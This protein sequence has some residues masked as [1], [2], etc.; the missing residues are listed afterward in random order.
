MALT[1][2]EEAAIRELLDQQA[3]LLSL[4]SNEA[5]I[6]SKLGATIAFL[7]D[8]AAASSVNAGDLLLLRQGTTD[9]SVTPEILLAPFFGDVGLGA[10]V[11][12][13]PAADRLPYFTGTGT[14]ALATL[15]ASG[16]ALIASGNYAAMRALLDLEPGV[17]VQAYDGDLAAI[18]AL[19]T[20]SFGRSLLTLAD[21][22]DF[23]FESGSNANGY[24]RRE[25]D[26]FIK[27]WGFADA[28]EPW[29]TAQ[30][31]PIPFT[32]F[33]SIGMQVTARSANSG[34]TSGNKVQGEKLTNSTFQVGSDD[35]TV[36]VFWSAWG[37]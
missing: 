1:G 4:A 30:S 37:F 17:D 10:L 6:S 12:L 36:T 24:W 34:A 23:G 11:G 29:S 32:I 19:T 16:R 28:G 13:T 14:S 18:A 3:A 33:D 20:T 5:S 9:K 21:M 2:A 15:T 8:L 27:Q 26:G 31:F 7:S 25:P 35:T 22:A